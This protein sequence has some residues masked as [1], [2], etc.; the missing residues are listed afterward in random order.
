MYI[1]YTLQVYVHATVPP[2]CYFSYLF[3]KLSW[4]E[5]EG[6]LGQSD[7]LIGMSQFHLVV[8]VKN[9]FVVLV[10][11]MG[12]LYDAIMAWGHHDHLLWAQDDLFIVLPN[13]CLWTGFNLNEKERVS[14]YIGVF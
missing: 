9:R 12:V 7:L 6:I 13:E 3:Q 11:Q 2:S 10:L 4:E 1:V 5:W 8:G 14:I